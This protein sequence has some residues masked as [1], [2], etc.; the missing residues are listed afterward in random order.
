MRSLSRHLD[1]YIEHLVASYPAT[2]RGLSL[3]RI[4]FALPIVFLSFSPKSLW[5]AGYPDVFWAPPQ[6]LSFFDCT[7]TIQFGLICGFP[8][9][10]V[11]LFLEAGVALTS[12]FILFGYRTFYSSIFFSAFYMLN[13]AFIYSTGKIDHDII[14]VITPAILSFSGWGNHFSLDSKQGKE[15]K[16]SFPSYSLL[17]LALTIAAGFLG[18]GYPKAVS[19]IDFDLSTSGVRSWGIGQYFGVEGNWVAPVFASLSNVW[20]WE[21]IDYTAVFLEIGLAF[22]VLSGRTFKVFLVA[23]SLFHFG[24]YVLLNISFASYLTVY[25]AFLPWDYISG[26]LAQ[27]SYTRCAEKLL[28]FKY[29]I[30]AFVLHLTLKVLSLNYS[31]LNIGAYRDI[32]YFSMSIAVVLWLTFRVLKNNKS[33]LINPVIH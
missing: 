2:E 7:G 5:V 29:L 19:W 30:L 26:K 20:I 15:V 11:L 17:F 33:I 16:S 22:S 27:Y 14:F 12:V 8:P 32:L 28:K 13:N 31:F 25:A 18:A 21:A 10:P 4:L 6:P 1:A 23:A 3:F 9:F 24:N